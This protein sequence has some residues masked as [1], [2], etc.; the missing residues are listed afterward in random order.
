M[1]AGVLLSCSSVCLL[2]ESTEKFYE[3]LV[4][5]LLPVRLN[6]SASPLRVDGSLFSTQSTWISHSVTAKSSIYVV[7]GK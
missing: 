4:I 3:I 2:Q 1:L 6:I 5:H 7:K